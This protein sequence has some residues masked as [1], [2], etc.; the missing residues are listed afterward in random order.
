ML[1]YAERP[2]ETEA[3][4]LNSAEYSRQTEM[5][6]LKCSKTPRQRML[7]YWNVPHILP[8]KRIM[9]SNERNFLDTQSLIY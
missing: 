2:R 1:K 4:L 8:D 6:V 5:Y 7:E 9:H 3:D